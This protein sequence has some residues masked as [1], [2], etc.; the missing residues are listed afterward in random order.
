ML[1]NFFFIIFTG[2]VRLFEGCQQVQ[3]S[4]LLSPT[5]NTVT[6]VTQKHLELQENH[7]KFLWAHQ[8]LL[9]PSKLARSHLFFWPSPLPTLGFGS[10]FRH[11]LAKY[12]LFWYVVP[13]QLNHLKKFSSNRPPRLHFLHIN[14]RHYSHISTHAHEMAREITHE[15]TIPG[16][17][18][19]Y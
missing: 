5:A 8:R 6:T 12:T 1:Y 15:I 7:P 16:S 13:S 4:L 18:P 9:P 3:K 14:S 2:W 19:V 10:S 11:P 17:S